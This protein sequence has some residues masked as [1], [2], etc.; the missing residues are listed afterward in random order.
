LDCNAEV[1][2]A[3]L[4]PGLVGFYQVSIRIPPSATPGDGFRL[5][6]STAQ[7]YVPL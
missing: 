7:A 6:C 5:T 3:G 4:A 2:F 1:V